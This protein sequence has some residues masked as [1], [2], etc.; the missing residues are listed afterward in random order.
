MD[1]KIPQS[2]CPPPSAAAMRM[3]RDTGSAVSMRSLA[4]QNG[5]STQGV[6]IA[7]SNSSSHMYRKLGSLCNR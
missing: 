4:P 3:V 6:K 1:Y 5:I 2:T 7:A